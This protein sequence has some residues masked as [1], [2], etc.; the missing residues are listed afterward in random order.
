MPCRPS[1]A[2]TRASRRTGC[3]RTGPS[4]PTWTSSTSPSAMRSS[5][6]ATRRNIVLAERPERP[7]RSRFRSRCSCPC[8]ASRGPT[9][10]QIRKPHLLLL[11]VVA[12]VGCA[13]AP[14]DPLFAFGSLEAPDGTPTTGTLSVL[15]ADCGDFGC[16]MIVPGPGNPGLPFLEPEYRPFTEV[17]TDADGTWMLELTRFDATEYTQQGAQMRMFKIVA[18]P[19]ATL[20][21]VEE[22]GRASCRE[23][24]GRVGGTG[25]GGSR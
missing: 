5:A 4:R 9:D 8:W 13:P 18:Q 7:T 21:P 23:G 10:M 11:F 15:R 1:G 25:E 16:D 14:E 6:T 17:T 3:S 20:P 24:G 12:I 22:I 19:D 2:S